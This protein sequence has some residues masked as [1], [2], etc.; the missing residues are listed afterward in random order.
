LSTDGFNGYPNAVEYALG[1]RVDYAQVV[2]E[3]ANAG[4]EEA[5]RYAPP[6]L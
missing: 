3:F 1:G 4:G 2:K 5:R 6:R